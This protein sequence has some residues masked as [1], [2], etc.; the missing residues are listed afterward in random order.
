MQIHSLQYITLK[1]CFWVITISKLKFPL[2]V[3]GVFTIALTEIYN[4]MNLD[5][6]ATNENL[7]YLQVMH[8]IIK[9]Q[10]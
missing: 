5:V 3:R 9:L 4:S 6:V 10:I 8:D 7:D 2:R 1:L